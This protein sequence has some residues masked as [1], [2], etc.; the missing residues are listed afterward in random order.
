MHMISSSRQLECVLPFDIYLVGTL[1]G[2]QVSS[3][4]SGILVP[5]AR[6]QRRMEGELKRE[7]LSTDFFR[8]L[9]CV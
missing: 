8:F 3:D 6:N 9:F 1:G 4:T 2:V 7:P 5:G